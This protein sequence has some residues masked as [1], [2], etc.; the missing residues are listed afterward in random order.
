[1]KKYLII[2]TIVLWQLTSMIVSNTVIIPGVVEIGVAFLNLF[3]SKLIYI[4]TLSTICRICAGLVISLLLGLTFAI[5][6]YLNTKVKEIMNPIISFLQSVPQISYIF[7]LLVWFNSEISLYVILILMLVPII[8][9]NVLTGL[10]NLDRDLKD[11]IALYHQP[12]IYNLFKV[13]LPL[14]RPYIE[15]SLDS[16]IPLSI[17]VIVMSEIL[18]SSQSGI[19]KLLYYARVQIDTASIIAVTIYMI[20]LIQVLLQIFHFIQRK[21]SGLN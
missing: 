11:V 1:M 15:A 8:Y 16:C 9:H 5:S 6:S 2:I 7:I 21:R 18:V 3:T 20:L 19:G 14:V 10:E 12:L 4:A 17:K 13:Y